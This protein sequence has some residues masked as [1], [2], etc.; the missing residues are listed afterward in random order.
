MSGVFTAAILMGF[1]ANALILL[2]G[3]R[4][5]YIY[6]KE[7]DEDIERRIKN[8]VDIIAASILII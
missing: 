8:P 4:T 6:H 2:S 5:F 3:C 1:I 7:Y